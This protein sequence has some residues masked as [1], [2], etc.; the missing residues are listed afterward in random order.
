MLL[1][2]SNPLYRG[3]IQDKLPSV[4]GATV[5]PWLRETY[6]KS[7]VKT[8]FCVVIQYSYDRRAKMWKTEKMYD[9][10]HDDGPD[11]GKELLPDWQDLVAGIV[12][13]VLN[14]RD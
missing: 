8:K 1:S 11:E 5:I 13:K 10:K 4:N 6:V 9:R 14:G 12:K 3:F 2:S 7:L